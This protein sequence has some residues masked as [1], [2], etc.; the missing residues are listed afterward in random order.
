MDEM[1]DHP[2]S[3]GPYFVRRV[4]GEGGMGVVYDA[5]QREP[6]RRRVAVKMMKLGMD[7][8]EV[9]ARFEA[10]RQSLAVMDHPGIAK[11]L[12]AGV[13]ADGRPY[14]AMELVAGI[15][16][17][18]YCAVN[19]LAVPARLLL[20][21]EVCQAVQHAHNKG[22]IHRDLKP[23]NILVKEEEGRPQPKIIDFGIAKATGPRLSGQ[24]VVTSFGQALGTLA[25]MSPEQ[26]EMSGLDVD[27]RT[28]VYAL[29][30][31]LYELLTGVVPVDPATFGAQR[32]VL[33]LIQRD[34]P[35][36]LLSAV[37]TNM[38]PERVAQLAAERKLEAT[39]LKR[40]LMGDVQWI[41]AKALE[42]DRNGRYETANALA[43]DLRRFVTNEPVAARPPSARYRF[44][45][46]VRRNRVGVMAGAFVVASLFLGTVGTT[47]GLVRARRAEARASREAEAANTTADFL[48]GLFKLLD[49]AHSRGRVVTGRELLDSGAFRIDTALA[50]EPEARARLQRTIGLVYTNLGEF[51]AGEPL[52]RAALATQTRRLGADDPQTLVT[53]FS[54]ADCHFYQA[55]YDEALALYR[56]VAEARARTVGRTHPSTLVAGTAIGTTLVML[57]RWDEAERTLIANREEAMQALGMRD[58]TTLQVLSSLQSLYFKRERFADAEPLARAVLEGRTAL[59]GADHPYALNA[60]HN[61]A[62]IHLRLGQFPLAERELRAVIGERRRVQGPLHPQTLNSL[63]YLAQAVGRQ[64]RVAEARQIQEDVVAGL[65]GTLGEADPRTQVARKELVS[66]ETISRASNGTAP[67]RDR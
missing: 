7:S 20:M 52:L 26:A 13:S 29:G 62:T 47:V 9:V 27:T 22:V 19:R 39:Q 54:L 67:Q 49:P 43:T 64:G 17:D 35:L 48:A 46:F 15:T 58:T 25:Y 65:A 4:I 8:K 28:D 32:F 24:T 55:N 18:E 21:A 50:G 23:G 31:I 10:E 12:D 45:K 61:L 41:V 63:G 56:R 16:I 36:P 44:G 51:R 66:L 37:L 6:V 38:A 2:R 5:E 33:Q 1:L 42:K 14:F 34:T 40:E 60:R 30:V 57:Q 59:L 53:A 3:I 11:V